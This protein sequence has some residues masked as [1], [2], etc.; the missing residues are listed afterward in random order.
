MTGHWGK[1]MHV[2]RASSSQAAVMQEG[3]G[4]GVDK[5]IPTTRA[6]LSLGTTRVFLG[7][8]VGSMTDPPGD[9]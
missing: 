9:P 6:A 7:A 1:G 3:W 2:P 5:L 4:G 8:E